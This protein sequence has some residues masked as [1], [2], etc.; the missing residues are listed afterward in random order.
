MTGVGREVRRVFLECN[1][2]TTRS[3]RITW[4]V[5][6][7]ASSESAVRMEKQPTR[8][9][10]RPK[11]CVYHSSSRKKEKERRGEEG[12]MSWCKGQVRMAVNVNKNRVVH[13]VGRT[14]AKDWLSI[15]LWPSATN[16]RMAYA[17]ASA[18]PEAKPW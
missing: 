17:S 14:F 13:G 7:S 1:V 11:F 15:T 3:V 4:L 9:P 10:Y 6:F 18:S 2:W 16:L 5:T 12:K 8:S